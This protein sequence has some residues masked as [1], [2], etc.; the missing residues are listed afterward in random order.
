[1]LDLGTV[2]LN[3]QANTKPVVQAQAAINK[4]SKSSK[5]SSKE[6]GFLSRALD[7]AAKSAQLTEGPLSGIAS[8]LV[9]LKGLL[10]TNTI[11]LAGITVALGGFVSLAS[12]A[13]RAFLEAEDGLV[14]LENTIRSTGR[15]AEITL[16]QADALA[17]GFDNLDKGRQAVAS[18][19]S[20]TSIPTEQLGEFL[21]TAEDLSKVLGRDLQG[22]VIG[23]AKAIENP[24]A[25]LDGLGRAGISFT[26][27][28]RENLQL[29]SDTGRKAEVTATIL[30]KIQERT[31][32]VAVD[33]GASGQLER[34]QKNAQ[35]F[36]EAIFK[37][38][39]AGKSLETT[40]S[41]IADLFEKFSQQGDLASRA[42][43]IISAAL[44][45]VNKSIS[46][47]IDNAGNLLKI[48]KIVSAVG[49]LFMA[50]S[51]ATA[52]IPAVLS[53]ITAIVGMAVAIAA[54][55]API[56]AIVLGIGLIGY[57]LG[58]TIEWFKSIGPVMVD[59]WDTGKAK[60]TEF[61]D[62]IVKK[63][64]E[65]IEPVTAAFDK[66]KQPFL[67]FIKPLQDAFNKVIDPIKETLSTFLEPAGEAVS[68]F[69]GDLVKDLKGIPDALETEVVRGVKSTVKELGGNFDDIKNK[70][71]S[72]YV[73]ISKT[74]PL[75]LLAAGADKVLEV[76]GKLAGGLV[77]LAG[78][79]HDASGA[80]ATFDQAIQGATESQKAFAMEVSPFL[81]I[82]DSYQ[83]GLRD[84]TVAREELVRNV[85]THGEKEFF[86]VMKDSL[87]GAKN[88]A[89]GLAFLDKQ[90]QDSLK[91]DFGNKFGTQF[92]T[93]IDN[94]KRLSD[95][96]TEIADDFDKVGGKVNPF[97]KKI[98]QAE[99]NLTRLGS[100][101]DTA[102]L[103]EQLKKLDTKNLLPD[104]TLSVEK[105][106]ILESAK[107]D[108]ELQLAELRNPI[109]KG[110]NQAIAGLG[111]DLGDKF[112][113][114]IMGDDST[115]FRDIAR[116]FTTK[117]ISTLITELAVNPLVKSF[118]TTLAGIMQPAAGAGG[119]G[120]SL[121]S[122][123][124]IV[125]SVAGM[126]S[127]AGAAS[128][129]AA[130]AGV[131]TGALAGTYG[132]QAPTT[133]L[134]IP[135]FAKG[136]MPQMNKPSIVGEKGP[137]LFIPKRKGTI[138]PNNKNMDMGG[139]TNVINF[140]V[141]TQDA[142]SFKIA[143]NRITQDLQRTLRN[144]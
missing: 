33:R 84:L 38:T 17:K 70:V 11:A 82:L 15:S 60:V 131:G 141:T 57:A 133:G 52:L 10:S 137:E 96:F 46:F 74:S 63:F 36:K 20:F 124:G 53:S 77:D 105:I 136:G 111:N 109:L 40:L 76:T 34:L 110:F 26:K 97:S 108:L 30:G 134:N 83:S 18:A 58:D 94:Q 123:L 75:D 48:L 126:A 130:G 61:T 54:S 25:A 78:F 99:D 22:A 16:E 106:K 89:E 12:S 28:Q 79:T 37:S 85:N 29:L 7:Q 80:M 14:I 73:A 103:E 101:L 50:K 32:G 81:Q 4:L 43:A 8:R 71:G 67:D 90:F 55:A 5:E 1:M 128:G 19:L 138:V 143:R 49:I 118:Q 86:E 41:G 95:S 68:K 87:G 115:S 9:T 51:L 69:T 102:K 125:G 66:I 140:N 64:N 114:K 93:F 88:L 3:I 39:T 31:K 132:I 127:G 27:I 116:S 117:L 135:K 35:L 139:N 45:S 144:S 98:R 23:I 129:A 44:T 21:S 112:A 72:M 92:D 47:L 65:L 122:I 42:G 62:Y 113:A 119:G 24:T 107:A 13:G 142:N 56:A 59:T 100:A 6:A 120:S 121:G 91:R 2:F 104:Q